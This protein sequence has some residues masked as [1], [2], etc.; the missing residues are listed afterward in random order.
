[1]RWTVIALCSLVT[2][3][4]SAQPQPPPFFYRLDGVCDDIDDETSLYAGLIAA[5]IVS[6]VAAGRAPGSLLAALESQLESYHYAYYWCRDGEEYY[7]RMARTPGADMTAAGNYA[8]ATESALKEAGTRFGSLLS[9]STVADGREDL[10]VTRVFAVLLSELRGNAR[11]LRRVQPARAALHIALTEILQL[12]TSCREVAK[13]GGLAT[14]CEWEL[15]TALNEAAAEV[16]ASFATYGAFAQSVGS[17]IDAAQ[18]QRAG[19]IARIAQL[20]TASRETRQ[21]VDNDL[22]PKLLALHEQ[23]KVMDA[24]RF[25]N[26]NVGCYYWWVGDYATAY[27]YWGWYGYYDH[28]LR[29]I[30]EQLIP[31]L[32]AHIKQL[33]D[34]A[35]AMDGEILTLQE[36]VRNIDTQASLAKQRLLAGNL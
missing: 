30:V 13:S 20:M 29:T 7:D 6:H 28:A 26:W 8:A 25:Y 14:P 23:A 35:Y 27:A 24:Q 1:M 34:Q 11:F 10:F 4:A 9:E 33:Q 32:T 12:S 31:S 18:A 22:N 36:S 15:E 16:R 21:M 17:A 5:R 2:G 19:N 3:V